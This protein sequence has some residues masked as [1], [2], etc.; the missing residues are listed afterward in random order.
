MKLHDTTIS[1]IAQI[2]QMAILTGTD[3]IDHL[4]MLSLELKENEDYIY[5]TEDY[6]N[7]FNESIQKML[8]NAQNLSNKQP[9]NTE[10]INDWSIKWNILKK[11][12]FYAFN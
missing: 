1:K 8:E 5:V 7:I 4:R 2:I 9:E 11:R 6:E 3:I 10:E 12:I